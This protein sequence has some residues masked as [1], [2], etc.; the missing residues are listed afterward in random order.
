MLNLGKSARP[1]MAAAAVL[2][3]LLLAAKASADKP[4]KPNPAKAKAKAAKAK[5]ALGK[6]GVAA[7]KKGTP[8]PYQAQIQALKTTNTLLAKANHDYKG[9]RV[10]AIHEIENA[11]QA[12]QPAG[13]KGG[14]GKRGGKGAGK[15]AGKGAGKPVVPLG[16][17]TVRPNPTKGRRGGG[18]AAEKEP[19][20]VS[21][22]QLR[23]AITQLQTTQAQLSR[24]GAATANANGAIARAIGQLQTALTI[25]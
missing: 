10:Q 3:V 12:L 6:R 1:A 24:F 5:S 4:N 17:T 16:G 15:V 25:K 11:I 19:Q 22:Q 13:G 21:D 20:A 18:A 23:T 7:G 8:S 2:G 14:M 9:H